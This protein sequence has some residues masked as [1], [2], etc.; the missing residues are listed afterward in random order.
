MRKFFTL[1][2]ITGLLSA[3]G[4]QKSV[5]ESPTVAPASLRD[6]PAQRLN[7]RF[8]P[9]VP[10]PSETA[11]NAQSEERNAAIQAD[12]DQ[13]RAQELL[14]KTI[15]SPDKQR[16]LAIYHNANDVQAEFRLDMYAPDGR[17]LKK[18]TYDGMAVHFPDTI[19]WSPDSKTI[20][21]VGMIRAGQPGGQP[22]PTPAPTENPANTATN[23]NTE[24]N[25]NV[26]T[27]T[28]P[29]PAAPTPQIEQ[30]QAVLTLG[31]EQIYIC[32]SEGTDLKLVTQ[33]Q[34]L[35]YFY[36]VWSPDS[37]MLA[38]LAATPQ[39]WTYLK[40]QSDLKSEIFIPFGRLRLVEKNGRERLLD[41]NLTKIRP[42]WSPDSAKVAI[43]F[44]TQV[45]IYDSIGNVPT[46]AAIQLRNQLLLSSKTYD[47]ELQRKE[48][49]G[50]ANT[51]PVNA[52]S[53]T[54]QQ[55]S[56]LPDESSLVS[57]SPIIELRWIEDKM[58]YA[59]TGYVKLFKNE[60][61][62]VRSYLRWHRLIFS[63]QPV[64]LGK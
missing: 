41:D 15:T 27:E 45:R 34:R 36:F 19:V 53:N 44:D 33:N 42:V 50:D 61:E 7:F 26:N 39:E 6:V 51:A 43:A 58:L 46:Q 52:E 24:T 4:C 23:T 47:E 35:I 32:S 22:L 57:F 40:D 13:N 49:G 54:N 12:F 9:D 21:F 48:A 2:F 14:D 25:A 31:T 38:A 5:F 28:A 16:V 64:T 3:F 37:S 29:T 56:T 63:P 62:S 60:A 1:I 8:E 55:V 18:I 20:A 17:R 10:A 59:Q 11:Q 30:P